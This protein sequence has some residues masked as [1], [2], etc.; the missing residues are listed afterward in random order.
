MRSTFERLPFAHF[1]E[2]TECRTGEPLELAAMAELAGY[3]DRDAIEAGWPSILDAALATQVK[4]PAAG[5]R[6]PFLDLETIQ[7]AFIRGLTYTGPV[8]AMWALFPTSIDR[9]VMSYLASIVIL[10]WGGSLALTYVT[11][12]TVLANEQAAWRR[13]AL[14]AT[15]ATVLAASIGAGLY[16]ADVISLRVALVGLLQTVYFFCAS[17][18]MLRTQYRFLATTAVLGAGAGAFSLFTSS[19]SLAG[20]ARVVTAACLAAPA[21]KLRS[22]AVTPGEVQEQHVRPDYRDV[23]S[24]ALYGIAFGLLVLWPSV[25][26]ATSPTARISLIIICGLAISETAV[27]YARRRGAK[28]LAISYHAPSFV[29]GTRRVISRALALYLIPVALS[30]TFICFRMA[31]GGQDA[32]LVVPAGVTVMGLGTVQILSLLCLALHGIRLAAGTLSLFVIVL[33][34]TTPLAN[35]GPSRTALYLAIICG[36]MISLTMAVRLL[37]QRPVNYL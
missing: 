11:G 18:L 9:T 4:T 34:S 19:P 27:A 7:R 24:Y 37:S 17:P 36:L 15:L 6:D 23:L 8:V 1:L 21:F 3:S 2:V 5:G 10:S 29:S 33:L 14:F 32:H 26:N 12:M 16:V 31:Q 28:L 30:I 22:L 35:E 13:A 25:A 20:A